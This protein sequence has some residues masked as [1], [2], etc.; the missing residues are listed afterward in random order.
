VYGTDD[1]LITDNEFARCP[2]NIA[3]QTP[4]TVTGLLIERNFSYDWGSG[5]HFR[6]G[7]NSIISDNLVQD[8]IDSGIVMDANDTC[9]SP[10]TPDCFYAIGNLITGNTATNNSIDLRHH[11]NALGNTWLDNVCETTEGIEIPPCIPPNP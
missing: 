3:E 10:P 9:P 7:S 2:I 4:G 11:P 8:H 6:G 1:A 5:I